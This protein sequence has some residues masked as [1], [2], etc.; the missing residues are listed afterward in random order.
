MSNACKL[1]ADVTVELC[2]VVA[3]MHTRVP[4]LYLRTIEA[5]QNIEV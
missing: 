5:T 3:D 4:Y 2:S 1:E